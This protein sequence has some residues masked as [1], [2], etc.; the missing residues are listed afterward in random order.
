MKPSPQGRRK[1]YTALGIARVHCFRH[2]TRKAVHQW[3]CCANG[4]RWIPICLQCDVDLNRMVLRWFR[5]PGR[6]ALMAKY[7]AKVGLL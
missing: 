5:L 3:N 1:P 2:P 7:R 4:N 6:H